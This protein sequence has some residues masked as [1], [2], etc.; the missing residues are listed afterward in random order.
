MISHFTDSEGRWT[1]H[2]PEGEWIVTIDA[3]ETSPGVREILRDMVTISSETASNDISMSTGEVAS[4]DIILYEDHSGGV[5]EGI[6]LE[7]ISEDGLGIIHLD[8]T[9][10]SG[11][12]G[13]D[14]PPGIW[15]IELNLTEDR[16]RWT[17]ESTN[18]SSFEL[19]AGENPSVNVTASRLIEIG[20]NVFWDFDDDNRSDLGEGISNVTIHLSSEDSNLSVVTDNSGDWRVFVPAG[21]FWELH[22]EIAGFSNEYHQLQMVVDPSWSDIELTAGSVGVR[23]NVSYIDEQQFSLISDSIVMEII[24]VSGFE[25]VSIAPNKVLINGSWNGEWE[26][27][28]EPGNWILRVTSVENNLIAMALIEAGVVEGAEIDIE[29]GVGGW[30][31]LCL[32]YTSPSPRDGLLSRMPSSA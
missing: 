24:P 16:K 4:F 13:A 9:D 15:N 27:E 19:V 17:I 3:F 7:L 31:N 25:R 14:V 20:S 29:L 2:I 18:E 28:I 23:G 10:S 21:S 5:L 12:V 26:A 30:L 32:L 6:S 1:A 22:T 8:S 11:E